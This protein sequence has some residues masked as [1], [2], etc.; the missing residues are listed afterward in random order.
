MWAWGVPAGVLLA[1]VLP[2]SEPREALVIRIVRRAW[3]RRATHARGN[4]GVS[5]TIPALLSH[6]GL[7]EPWTR[8]NGTPNSTHGEGIDT[9]CLLRVRKVESRRARLAHHTVG[10]KVTVELLAGAT[11]AE[12]PPEETGEEEETTNTTNYTTG[13]S[14]RIRSTATA[15]II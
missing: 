2:R 7:R 6:L 12:E 9:S 15:A 8:A 3:R 14:A 4:V 13:D 11:A 10:V 5:T 1:H